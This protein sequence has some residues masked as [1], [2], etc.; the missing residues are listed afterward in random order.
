MSNSVDLIIEDIN[1]KEEKKKNQLNNSDDEKKRKEAEAIAE[2]QQMFQNL[3]L[4][5]IIN[6]IKHYLESEI[7]QTSFSDNNE[8]NIKK[9]LITFINVNPKQG[10]LFASL[11]DYSITEKQNSFFSKLPEILIINIDRVI[12]FVGDRNI[13]ESLFDHQA[14]TF[15]KVLY[16]DRFLESNRKETLNRQSVI[17]ELKSQ[18]DDLK[19]NLRKYSHY[20]ENSIGIDQLLKGSIQFLNDSKNKLIL[21]QDDYSDEEYFNSIKQFN[22]VIEQLSNEFDSVSEEMMS[23]VDCIDQLQQSIDTK[24]EDMTEVQYH[25]Y[26]ILVHEGPADM[27]SSWAFIYNINQEKWYK[28]YDS[29]VSVVSE[30]VVMEESSGKNNNSIVDEHNKKS[31]YSLLYVKPQF[32]VKIS[33]EENNNNN[34]NNEI[35]DSD[36][37]DLSKRYSNSKIN[38]NIIKYGKQHNEI[39]QKEIDEFERRRNIAT[40]TVFDKFKRLLIEKE[41]RFQD[42]FNND[43]SPPNLYSFHIFLESIDQKAHLQYEFA[44]K[45]HR[46]LCANISLR[47]NEDSE[48]RSAI[49]KDFPLI[50]NINEISYQIPTYKDLYNNCIEVIAYTTEAMKLYRKQK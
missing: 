48:F 30:E 38:P 34:N 40:E 17:K 36:I 3:T 47:E 23:Y 5:P 11:I 15:P 6:P 33:S 45:V 14:F 19:T 50:A 35:N 32:F 29:S 18:Q 28:F 8:E 1:A 13:N 9:E 16:L 41:T 27:G 37:N 2:I 24:F 49:A 43:L 22:D 4:T 25:L 39:F 21:N 42:T 7:T 31:T 10:E 44:D 26:A 12:K 46:Q 20:N